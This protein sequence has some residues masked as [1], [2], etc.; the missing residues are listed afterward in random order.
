MAS[1]I[2]LKRSAVQGSVPSTLQEAE[3]A[4]N[5]E[6]KK[7]FVGGVNGG[8]NVQILSGDLY[9][10]TSENG[11]DSATITLTVDNETLSNDSIT[12]TA[13]E[14]IDISESSGTITISGENA[15]DTNKGVAS[16]DSGD[17]S[18][19]SGA[20]TLADSTDGAVLTINGTSNE[21]DVSRTNGTVTI[22]LPDDVT[23]TGQLNVSENVVA[24]GNVVV[25]N[26]LDV[27][28][29]SYFASDLTVGACT[30]FVVTASD[31]SVSTEGNLNVD[32]DTT[33]NGLTA[34]TFTANGT[35]TFVS[36]VDAQSTLNVDG[37]TTLNGVTITTMTANGAVTVNGLA[38]LDGG[39]DVDGAFT[40]ADT[41]GNID[42]TGTLNVDG[43]TTLNGVTTTTLTANGIVT[44]G[45]AVDINN[46][47]DISGQLNIGEN[48]VVAGNTSVAGSLTVDGDLN[49]EGALTYLA[50][51]TV[52]T[53]DSMIKLSA[54]NIADTIDHGV[55]SK[56]VVGV[57]TK[58]AGYFRDSS[59][60]STFKF[61]RDLEVEPTSTVNVSGTG[62][63]LATVEAVIDG[64][65]Y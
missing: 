65:T 10:L 63:T 46:D 7:L 59:E 33:V 41:S 44:I 55:Y 62:Y 3:I 45:G 15:S 53:D 60:G 40:V 42:T 43:A 49:V 29:L 5:L 27:T 48:L 8:A 22:G 34:T 64:G 12:F 28:G 20:V 21:V 25:G 50:T 2:K 30:E 54:N 24:T 26:V 51:Q 37:D 35:A 47:A 38:S 57:T 16:F 23:I 39:I 61:Y 11:S 58:Y 17:F 31:G 56:Y 1:I 19:S 9:N 36:G 6:D 18:V 13:G 14:G 4:V 52:Q 32:G